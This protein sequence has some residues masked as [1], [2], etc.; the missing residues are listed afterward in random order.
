MISRASPVVEV[1]CCS[2]YG[3]RDSVSINTD[4]N[5]P[6]NTIADYVITGEMEESK[7]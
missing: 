7:Q 6:I 1:I 4:P 3:A 2:D 5:A